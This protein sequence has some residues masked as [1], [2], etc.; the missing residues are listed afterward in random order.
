[1]NVNRVRQ[2]L[3]TSGCSA[4]AL[5]LATMAFAPSASA[6]AAAAATG[7]DGNP[8]Q[9]EVVVTATRR[10]ESTL[11][12]P[13]SII[14]YDQRSLDV[15]AVRSLDDLTSLTPGLDLTRNAEGNGTLVSISIRGIVANGQSPTTGVYIDDTP[16][17]VRANG[18]SLFGTAVPALFDLD[19]VEVLRGPQGTLFGAGAEGGAV[20]FITP[21][22]SLTHYSAYARAEVAGTENGGPSGEIGLAVGGPII[23]DKL[24][25]RISGDFRHDGGYID[26]VSYQTGKTTDPDSNWQDTTAI[27]AALKFAPTNWLTITPSVFYQDQYVH[28]T[29]YYWEQFSN[30]SKEEF[31][32]AKQ[33]GEPSRDKYFLPALKIEADAGFADFVSATSYMYRKG[34]TLVDETNLDGSYFLPTG[35]YFTDPAAA[36]PEIDTAEFNIFTQE[37]RLQSKP[38]RFQWIIGGFYSNLRDQEHQADDASYFSSAITGALG[39]LYQG[40]YFYLV[41][42]SSLDQQWAGFAEISYEFIHGLRLTAGARYADLSLHYLRSADGPLYGPN[43][44]SYNLSSG[45]TSVTPKFNL[46]YQ[47]NP[48]TMVYAMAN[49]GTREGGINRAAFPLPPCLAAIAQLGLSQF[50]TTYKPDSLWNYELGT[51]DRFFGGKVRVEA[52]VFY[53]QWADIQRLIAPP[54]CGGSNFTGNLGNAT[55]KGVEL[56]LAVQPIDYLTLNLQMAYTDATFDH[57]LTSTGIVNNVPVTTTYVSAGDTLGTPPWVVTLSGRYEHP[58]LDEDKRGYFQAEVTYRSHNGGKTEV[59]DPATLA[60]YDPD[61]PLPDA[62]TI[63][64]LRAGLLMK[65]ADIALFVNNLLDDHPALGRF[66]AFSGDPLYLNRTIQPRTFGLSL[67][68]HY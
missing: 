16:V 36:S 32:N 38:G 54:Q 10:A 48:D 3:M 7:N 12:V 49:Q 6:A 37:F 40:K 21:E 39:P 43:H 51:K 33:L 50:P 56:S 20:R 65:G 47:I 53:D 30:P 15:Q 28:D 5:G 59:Q 14:A 68:Y 34:T 52:A 25:F 29:T 46:T 67:T 17:Q 9:S 13:Q 18:L 8:M 24:A 4:L 45:S 66:H 1:M 19:R 27:H 26:H 42:E 61:I 23:E 62:V 11:K 64:K 58:I 60:T 2:L 44:L 41:T 55:S 22:P 57:T 63:V 35:P 31:R